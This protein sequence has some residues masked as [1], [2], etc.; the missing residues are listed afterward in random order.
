MHRTFG[1]AAFLS[2]AI[3]ASPV[4]ALPPK[5]TCA[6]EKKAVIPLTRTLL[7]KIAVPARINGTDVSMELDTGASTLVTPTTAATLKLPRDTRRTRAFGTTAVL[8]VNNVILR[9]IE[10]GG[11]RETYKSVPSIAVSSGLPPELESKLKIVTMSGLI[12]NDTLARYDVE[13]DLGE[14]RITLHSVTGCRG[15]KPEW[16]GTY[17]TIPLIANG[18]RRIMLPVELDGKRVSAIF[19]TGASQSAITKTAALRL[20]IKA[21]DLAKQP[22]QTY[23]GVGDVKA[24]LA[25]Y[26]F[27]TVKVGDDTATNMTFSVLETPLFNADMLLGLDYMKRGKFWISNATRTLH[28]QMQ[29]QPAP[30][31][32]AAGRSPTEDA[33]NAA[34]KAAREG[35]YQ[36]TPPAERS[37]SQPMPAKPAS[38]GNGCGQTSGTRAPDCMP[39]PKLPPPQYAETREVDA[40]T[41]RALGIANTFGLLV[42]VPYWRGDGGLRTGDVILQID[43]KLLNSTVLAYDAISDR[44]TGSLVPM[45][46]WRNGATASLQVPVVRASED[47]RQHNAKISVPPAERMEAELQI[48]RL[49]PKSYFPSVWWRAKVNLADMYLAQKEEIAANTEKAI[50]ALDEVT[51]S[52]VPYLDLADT[53]AKLAGAYRRRAPD[54]TGES[55][56]NAIAALGKANTIYASNDTQRAR[57]ARGRVQ[58]DLASAYMERKQGE[59]ADN[60]EHAIAAYQDALTIFTSHIAPRDWAALQNDLGLAYTLRGKGNRKENIELAIKA[61]TAALTYRTQQNSPADHDATSRLLVSAQA[62]LKQI[63]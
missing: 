27:K 38:S 13:L 45:I 3:L 12:G 24:N 47:M 60:I 52:A 11:L 41:F 37:S 49:Y 58:F 36:L 20:G 5:E 43:G 30:Q 42:V 29:G 59:R 44:P 10:F 19:D 21:D 9:E 61:F 56:E 40:A 34:A 16:T 1:L 39:K 57:L 22:K 7:G 8:I 4:H 28:I 25:N 63:S 54:K 46:V 18:L 15:F 26:T 33:F 50:E 53:Y 2:A 55:L 31:V 48:T 35:H 32:A 23:S 14:R 6:I 17:S 51:R 62:A